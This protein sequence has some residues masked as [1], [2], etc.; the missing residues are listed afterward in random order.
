MQIHRKLKRLKLTQIKPEGWLKRQLEIQMN[1]LSGKLHKIW[2]SVGSYSGW[3]GGTGESWERAP[4]YLDGLL[5]LSWYLED[6]EQMELCERFV[7]WTL[8]SQTEDGNFGPLATSDDYWSRYVMLKVLIQYAEISGDVRVLPF[9]IRYFQYIANEIEYRPLINWS[10]SRVPDLLYCMKWAFE[11]SRDCRIITYAKMLSHSGYDWVDYLNCFPFPRPS[12]FYFNWKK[13]IHI[14]KEEHDDFVPYHGTHIVNVAM[15]IKH[16]AMEYAFTGDAS[17]LE[18]LYK[19]LGDLD[20]YHGVVSGCINGDEHLAGNDPNRGSELCFVVEAMFSLAASIEIF[21][22]IE[23][24]DRLERL[25]YNALPATI[26]EDFMSHQYLQQANQ[27]LCTDE[28]RPWFNNNSDASTF[29]L[30]PNF[31][32]C[33]ANM[34]Q[35]WPKLVNALWFQEDGDTFVSMIIAPS[36]MTSGSGEDE[37]RIRLDTEYPFKDTLAYSFLNAPNRELTI[38]IR[39][40]HWCKEPEVNGIKVK[41][42]DGYIIRS[43]TFQDN[44]V[45]HIKLPMEV[46]TTRWFHNSIAV[47]RG[48]FVFGLNIREKWVPYKKLAG[49]VDYQVH[50]ESEW[51]YA[52]SSDLD[53]ITVESDLCDIPFSKEHAPVTLI[54]NAKRVNGWTLEG[55]NAGTLPH[56]PIRVDSSEEKIELIPFGCTKLRISE[57]PTYHGDS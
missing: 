12:E 7:N 1:G 25:A 9:M 43:S 4:Y 41:P 39:V 52:L 22:E 17:M 37:V 34:H 35:G 47:E 50:P 3:L 31:G 32:C 23:L 24:A 8:E 20:H 26:S 40:P 15:G 21:G 36:S 48:P 45:L 13:I 56:S 42:H 49:T 30:E 14:N 46:R 10:K 18:V 5:P 44:E 55:G 28:K 11:E 16:P 29:G 6:S 51:N 53:A 33:T 19:G 27:V 57:F 54:V 2:D 38:K